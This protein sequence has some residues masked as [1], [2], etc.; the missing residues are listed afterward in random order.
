M[1]K[2]IFYIA[3]TLEK[4]ISVCGE[5]A[6]TKKAIPLL[7]GAGLQSFSVSPAQLAHTIVSAC[8]YNITDTRMLFEKIVSCSNTTEII[9]TTEE[10]YHAY[11]SDSR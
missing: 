11:N 7:L 4:P 10:F 1:I 3:S 5:M 6:N 2:D 8:S 9:Q